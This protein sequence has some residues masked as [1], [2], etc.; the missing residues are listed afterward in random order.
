MQSKISLKNNPKEILSQR[1]NVYANSNSKWI[2][3]F[4]QSK[5]WFVNQE[6]EEILGEVSHEIVFASE[7]Q[8]ICWK[9]LVVSEQNDLIAWEFLEKFFR[10]IESRLRSPAA[11]LSRKG[12]RD[13]QYFD[14]I[15]RLSNKYLKKAF[16]KFTVQNVRKKKN[17]R[18]FIVVKRCQE[19]NRS[20]SWD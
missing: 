12:C 17:K 1:K 6:I 15:C 2:P 19:R 7:T 18:I 16:W 14:L 3:E 11:W 10:K 5:A 13:L 4:H 8:V 20:F 9:R